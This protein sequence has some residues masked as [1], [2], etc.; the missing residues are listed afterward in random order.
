MPQSEKSGHLA[1]GAWSSTSGLGDRIDFVLGFVR[2]RYMSIAIFLAAALPI[3]AAYHLS[4]PAVYT[5]S[6]TMMIET[7]QS[8]VAQRFG[9]VSQDAAWI[10]SQIGI[11]KSHSV[12]AYVVKQLRLADEPDFVPSPGLIDRAFDW[13]L[14]RL[15]WSAESGSDAVRFNQATGIVLSGLNVR[16]VGQSYMLRID[17]S[18]GHPEHAAKVAN[19]MADAYIFDQLNSKYQANRRAGDWLQERLQ[20]L[21]EQAASAERAVVE[22]K[23]K[24]NIVTAGGSLMSDKQLSEA[25]S[26]LTAARANAVDLQT[27]LDRIGVVRQSYQKDQP[28]SSVDETV[29][30]AMSNPII[31][32][33]R[34]RYLDLMNRE[35]DWS[36]RYG[37]NH[38]AVANLR[39]QIRDIRRSILDELGRIE[40]TFRSEYAIAKKREAELEKTLASL[41]GQTTAANQAQVTLYSLESAAQ[42]YRKLYDNFLQRHTETVQQQSFPGTDARLLSPASVSK[43]GPRALQIW[44][45]TIFAGS[46]L[47]IGFGVF[48]EIMDRGFR[49]REQ[50][51]SVLET[52]CL[53]LVPLLP[54][55]RA[56][57]AARPL[58][59]ARPDI[60]QSTSGIGTISVAPRI[61]RAILE[62]PSSPYAEAIRS[63]KLTIDQILPKKHPKVIGLTSSVPGEGKSTLALAIATLIAQSGGRVMLIDCDLSNPSLSRTLTP[64]ARTGFLDVVAGT[65]T[66]DDAIWSYPGGNMAFL[67]PGDRARTPNAADLLNSETAKTL[68]NSLHLK[69]DYVI[70]DLAPL[71]A[72]MDIRSTSRLVDSY[73]LAIEW[74]TTKIDAVQYSLRN[75]PGVEGRMVGVVLNKVDMAT[76]NHYDHYGAQYY[77]GHDRA[78]IQ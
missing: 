21:R 34:T 33:M 36:I 62:N 77:Y 72:S 61:V 10:E 5:A 35:A 53:A 28:D 2:R 54:V 50:V 64:E 58:L 11:L 74:G 73:L 45:T 31:N 66:L 32:G 46:A 18:A 78:T 40:E 76:L 30:E 55:A 41:L 1:G 26:R 14:R 67:P 3:G 68:I 15:G 52:E 7:R 48:R 6:A 12:A 25:S 70:I 16:R 44:L 29:S 65:T 27:R 75:A 59:T 24:N 60:T 9:E 23:A 47:G 4:Q 43:T 56:P 69:Y 19:A 49:T 51:R 57:S 38:V 8:P 17:F 20:S 13:L 63:I 71:V 22:Y 42:S 39:N 37:K